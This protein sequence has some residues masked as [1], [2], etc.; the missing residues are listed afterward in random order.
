[1]NI[2]ISGITGLIGTALKAAL[3]SSG[4]KVYTL[5]RGVHGG[6]FYWTPEQNQIH[7]DKSIQLDAVICLNGVNIGDKRWSASRKQAILN[8]RIQSTQLLSRALAD[9]PRP[10]KVFISGSAIGF[11][12]DTQHHWKDESHGPGHNFLSEIVTRW[13]AAAQPAIHRGIRTVFIRSGVVLSPKG[14]ALHKMLLPFKLGLGGK[15]GHGQ[16]FMSWI[17]LEDEV[18]AI[19][20]LIEQTHISGPVNLT[21][22][23]PVTNLQL[24]QSLGKALHRPTLLPMPE[25]MVKLL[26]G[27][28]GELLLLGSNRIKSN[29]LQAN[30]FQFNHIDIQSALN[31]MLRSPK[32]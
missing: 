28:M 13:E 31:A 20:F 16:Q 7:L 24:T 29:V 2:L 19:Q 8:S 6:S 32:A 10:P 4:H 9:L 30:G 12:G 14:G 21:A 26:F 17:S 18:R 15:V 22:P 5:H 3:K 1:M 27:E 11:Y 25:G 23:N